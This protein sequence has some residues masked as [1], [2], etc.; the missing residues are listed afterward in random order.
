MAYTS[1]QLFYVAPNVSCSGGRSSL[2]ALNYDMAIKLRYF[3]GWLEKDPQIDLDASPVHVN[4]VTPGSARDV[5]Y[6]GSWC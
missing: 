4:A 3:E 1:T 2:S 5:L 6:Y